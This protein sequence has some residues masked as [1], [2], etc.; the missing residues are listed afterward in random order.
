V[1]RLASDL[2]RSARLQSGRL[3]RAANK[4]I[5]EQICQSEATVKVHVIHIL[6]KLGRR[7]ERRRSSLRSGAASSISRDSVVVPSLRLASRDLVEE[8]RHHERFGIV[9]M[10]AQLLHEEV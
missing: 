10:S 9:E 3:V 2:I 4:Q 6:Q 5:A 1:S 8:T 7:I